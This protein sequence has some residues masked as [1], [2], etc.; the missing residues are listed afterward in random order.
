MARPQADQ[1]IRAERLRGVLL[2]GCQCERVPFIASSFARRKRT[3]PARV[4]DPIFIVDVPCPIFALDG[5]QG[6]TSYLRSLIASASRT[7]NERSIRKLGCGG[8]LPRHD[9][10]HTSSCSAAVLGRQQC[11][12]CGPYRAAA[13][14]YEEVISG[15]APVSDAMV[16]LR[17][18]IRLVPLTQRSSANRTSVRNSSSR[19]RVTP[20]QRP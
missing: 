16:A 13:A 8:A 12:G 5:S 19:A 3:N 2:D 11:R 9:T 7:P 10:N 18:T 20:S 1:P 6:K 14:A 4:S 17:R 15:G